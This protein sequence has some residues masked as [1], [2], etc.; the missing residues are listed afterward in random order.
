MTP[1]S[2]RQPIGLILLSTL[3][4][5]PSTITQAQPH[6]PMSPEIAAL[7][8]QLQHPQADERIDAA[9]QLGE[10]GVAATVPD[11]IPL[12]QDADPNVRISASQAFQRMKESASAAIPHLIPLLKDP[13]VEVRI[14]VPY[15]LGEMGELAIDAVS[16][17]KAMGQ[18]QNVN[19]AVSAATALTRIDRETR[20]TTLKSLI[21]AMQDKDP[22]KRRYAAFGLHLMGRFAQEAIPQL[23]AL[24]RDPRPD[25]QEA[26][27]AVLA[28]ISIDAKIAIPNPTKPPQ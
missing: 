7:V 1:R 23:Q 9:N 25:V 15:A 14:W 28:T 22:K 18:D 12:L 13:N 16:D 8:Q 24:R 3:L 6:P 19:I 26:A 17:L 10:M 4:A 21:A 2:F 27:T 11:L 20:S 5:F